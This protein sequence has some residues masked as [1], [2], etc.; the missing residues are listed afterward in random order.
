MDL[1]MRGGVRK[2]RTI[3]F[4]ANK[5]CVPLLGTSNMLSKSECIHLVTPHGISEGSAPFDLL[6]V[7]VPKVEYHI[8]HEILRDENQ[9]EE[10][11]VLIENEYIQDEIYQGILKRYRKIGSRIIIPESLQKRLNLSVGGLVEI[12]PTYDLYDEKLG[13]GVFQINL[14]IV[15]ITGAGRNCGK[16]DMTLVVREFFTTY[17]YDVLCFASSQIAGLWG[18]EK[19]PKFLFED[20][21]ITEKVTLFNHFLYTKIHEKRPEIVVICVP[22]GIIAQN[23]FRYEDIG[24]I[25]LA[26]SAAVPVSANLCC[27][28]NHSYSGPF[29][30]NLGN[31]C[32]YK[33][34]FTPVLYHASNM[35]FEI[36]PEYRKS[37]VMSGSLDIAIQNVIALRKDYQRRDIFT[38]YDENMKAEGLEKLLTYLTEG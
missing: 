29:L 35:L 7:F 30:D 17:G 8:T 13:N 24:E 23:P 34:G 18:M 27:L 32:K 12:L 21:S 20:R 10:T 4:G 38:I 33:Y 31:I 16:F 25:V 22:G 2:M 28:Y 5:E 1:I 37:E 11:L 36:D 9:Q 14:P 26:I 19:L 3:I 6:K 15:L